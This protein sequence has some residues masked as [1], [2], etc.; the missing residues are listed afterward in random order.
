MCWG[1][2]G[3][4]RGHNKEALLKILEKISKPEEIERYFS[5]FMIKSNNIN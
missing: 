4:R 5:M 1:C 2:F 3:L